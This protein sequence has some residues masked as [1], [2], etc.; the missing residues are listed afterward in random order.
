MPEMKSSVPIKWALPGNERQDSVFNG[1]CEISE[2]ARLVAI[3][4]SARTMVTAVDTR[5][6]SFQIRSTTAT[7]NVHFVKANRSV[8]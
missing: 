5:F 4:D 8:N 3:H 1:L 2:T 6:D 7:S